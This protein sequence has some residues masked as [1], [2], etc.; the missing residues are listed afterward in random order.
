MRRKNGSN[1]PARNANEP[2]RKRV[3]MKRA[4]NMPVHNSAL[5]RL[6]NN[7][8]EEDEPVL[9]PRTRGKKKV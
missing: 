3:R 5:R 7:N 6:R 8:D 9:P 2:V 4:S 1:A